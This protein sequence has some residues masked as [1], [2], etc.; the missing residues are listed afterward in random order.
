MFKSE[1]THCAL[2]S[3]IRT[4][5]FYEE[6]IT[7]DSEINKQFCYFYK[8]LYQEKLSFCKNNLQ[9]YL[10]TVSTPA[11]C[12]EQQDSFEGKTSE[13]ELLKSVKSMQNEKLPENDA[14]S[15]EFYETFWNNV[16]NLFY[17]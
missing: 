6:Q 7:N 14:L 17:Q 3:Q 1:K 12:K 9:N 2:Q 4:I 16:E 11:L 8:S 10:G 15:K 5:I 13:K